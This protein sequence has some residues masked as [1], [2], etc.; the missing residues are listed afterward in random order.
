MILDLRSVKSWGAPPETTDK[1]NDLDVD[2]I[3][4]T[5]KLKDHTGY[6]PSCTEVQRR[7]DAIEKDWTCY[8]GDAALAICNSVACEG[9]MAWAIKGC[10]SRICGRTHVVFYGPKGL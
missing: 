10:D 4:V 7:C 5:P 8:N 3:A 2:L 6:T 9:A 1:T